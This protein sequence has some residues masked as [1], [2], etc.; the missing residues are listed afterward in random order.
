MLKKLRTKGAFSKSKIYPVL[1]TFWFLSTLKLIPIKGAGK[2]YPKVIQLPITYFCNARC[3]M[4]DVWNM[5]HSGELTPQELKE[6]LSDPIFKKV[7]GV[8]INGGEPSLIKNLDEYAAVIIDQCPKL[9]SL[10]IISHGFHTSRLLALLKSIYLL[11]NKK[12]ISF[13]VSVSLDGYGEIHDRVR[14]IPGVF[15]KTF[16]TI[17]KI[18]TNMPLSCVFL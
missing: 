7:E 10:N 14:G 2:K 11:C 17:N 3:V 18:K 8:G 9:K 1:S 5:D 6:V 4:C 12:G 16:E 15:K 13:H